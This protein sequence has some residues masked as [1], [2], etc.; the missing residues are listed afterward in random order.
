[1]NPRGNV[2]Q[3]LARLDRTVEAGPTRL[4]TRPAETS[5]N[6]QP[7]RA[8]DLRVGALEFKPLDC[9]TTTSVLSPAAATTSALALVTTPHLRLDA[10]TF[11]PSVPS[12]PNTSTILSKDAPEFEL[13]SARN[14]A[15]AKYLLD[16]SKLLDPGHASDGSGN[17]F[18]HARDAMTIAA[19]SYCGY[20]AQRHPLR[21]EVP[22]RRR[23]RGRRTSPSLPP[24]PSLP[25]PPSL[26]PAPPLPQVPPRI[27]RARPQMYVLPAVVALLERQRL[28][29]LFAITL[30]QP[31]SNLNALVPRQQF[32]VRLVLVDDVAV[33]YLL[34][35][36]SLDSPASSICHYVI[37]C[38]AVFT[39]SSTQRA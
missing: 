25:P 39:A 13:R 11:N 10:P 30:T 20:P 31:G 7:S 26:P 35:R 22:A 2:H 18:S 34:A 29:P 33:A 17:I 24:A 12:R 14:I 4:Q 23:R 28:S 1:M 27:P 8:S 21:F 3:H 16:Q 32:F 6:R 19:A 37:S 38:V 5:A 9:S 36:F 15:V